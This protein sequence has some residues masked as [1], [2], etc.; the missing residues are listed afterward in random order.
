[1]LR[2]P[3]NPCLSATSNG[4]SRTSAR[5][6]S[7]QQVLSTS[8]LRSGLKVFWAARSGRPLPMM[9]VISLRPFTGPFWL[10][11]RAVGPGAMR[12][13]L[14]PLLPPVCAA[15][16]ECWAWQLSCVV[17]AQPTQCLVILLSIRTSPLCASTSRISRTPFCF[18]LCASSLRP[19]HCI[20]VWISSC[21]IISNLFSVQ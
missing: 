7:I 17:H 2:L 14:R 20:L 5:S 19:S 9:L 21:S 11:V 10:R 12:R 8:P 15:P 1:M 18:L 3:C 13:P 6:S 16:R 4:T